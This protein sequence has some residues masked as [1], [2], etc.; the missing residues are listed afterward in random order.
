LDIGS[1]IQKELLETNT[2]VLTNFK[3]LLLDEINKFIEESIQAYNAWNL[4]DSKVGKKKQKAFVSA[5]IF[6]AQNCMVVSTKLFIHGYP[7]PSGNLVRTGL[8]SCAMAI[9]C[10]NKELSY[11]E[12]IKENEFKASQAFKTLED[13]VDQFG[14]N[15]ASLTEFKKLW[16][17]YHGYSHATL[18]SLTSLLSFE[19]GVSNI[20]LGSIFDANKKDSYKKELILRIN[21]MKNIKNIISGIIDSFK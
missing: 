21:I 11:Y 14:I 17:W 6:N 3:E 20:H 9:L 13:C 5:F 15:S 10:S 7:V 12:K 19:S 16:A 1:V 18:L 2:V 4:W 8:E